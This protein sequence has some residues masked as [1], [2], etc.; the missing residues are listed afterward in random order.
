MGCAA[1]ATGLAGMKFV[2]PHVNTDTGDFCDR[3]I[4]SMSCLATKLTHVSEQKGGCKV[5]FDVCLLKG[6]D[7]AGEDM[8]NG[9]AV[10][11]LSEKGLG[12]HTKGEQW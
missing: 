6:L 4:G 1:S 9:K 8:L 5:P 10:A 7:L 3:A 12:N 2:V 11:S